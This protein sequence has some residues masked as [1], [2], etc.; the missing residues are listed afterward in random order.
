MR[1]RKSRYLPIGSVSHGT[2]RPEDVTPKLLSLADM[3]GMTR[4]DRREVSRLDREWETSDKLD[5]TAADYDIMEQ[6]QEILTNYAPPFFY[7]GSHPGDGSDIGVWLDRDALDSAI[8]EG[9]VWADPD[10]GS[11]MPAEASGRL[12]ISDHGNM[13]LYTRRGREVWGIV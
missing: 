4:E 12:A 1:N 9:E 2:L 8:H 11:K 13:T 5:D 3:V 10:D 6:L 7:V